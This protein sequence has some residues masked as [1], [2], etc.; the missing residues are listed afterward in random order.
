VLAL[1]A[2]QIWLPGGGTKEEAGVAEFATAKKR[3]LAK[4]K[5]TNI[6]TEVISSPKPDKAFF[7]M[8][9]QKLK[10][11]CVIEA[12]ITAAQTTDGK[13]RTHMANVGRIVSRGPDF[14]LQTIDDPSQGE[15]GAGLDW[16][17]PR[18]WRRDGSSYGFSMNLKDPSGGPKVIPGYELHGVLIECKKK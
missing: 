7:E 12:H 15:K 10:E 8:L 14:G 11:G 2:I 6:T 4:L 17:G 3:V 9:A 5:I 16:R 13:R 1:A 18:L